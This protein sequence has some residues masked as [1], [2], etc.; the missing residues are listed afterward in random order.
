[1][2]STRQRQGARCNETTVGFD[3]SYDLVE[4]TELAR[5]AGRRF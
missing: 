3:V 4:P 1:M 2:T 5:Y